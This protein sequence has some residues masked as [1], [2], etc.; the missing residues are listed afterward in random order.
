MLAEEENF[1][2]SH[3][4]RHVKFADM[5]EGGLTSTPHNLQEEVALPAKPTH[6]SHPEE[7]TLH[8]AAHEFRKMWEPNIVSKSVVT[9][10]QLD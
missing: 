7:I 1:T 2:P 5:M 9:P 6:E 4:P 3:Q 10:C 8:M